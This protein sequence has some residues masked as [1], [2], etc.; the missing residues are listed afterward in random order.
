[1]QLLYQAR[2]NPDQPCTIYLEQEEWQL[3][4]SV[5]GKSPVISSKLPT[6]QQ[7]VI[8]IARLGGYLARNNDGPPGIKN[9]WRGLQQLNAMTKAINLKNQWFSTL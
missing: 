6:L 4:V 3:L 5:H 1:M 7:C 9:L 8:L 2:T